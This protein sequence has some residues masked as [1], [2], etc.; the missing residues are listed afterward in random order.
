[1]LPN[2]SSSPHTYD[3]YGLSNANEMFTIVASLFMLHEIFEGGWKVFIRI[4]R[5]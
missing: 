2:L 5:Y 1:M 4:E 3:C